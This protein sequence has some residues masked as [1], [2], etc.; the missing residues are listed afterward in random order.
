MRQFS[1]AEADKPTEEY[2]EKEKGKYRDAWGLKYDDECLKFEKEWEMI[3]EKV[4]AE[5]MVYLEKELGDL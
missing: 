5:Q 1:A 2:S 4:N 3:S